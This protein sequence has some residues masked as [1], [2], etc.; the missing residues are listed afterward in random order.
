MKKS[1]PKDKQLLRLNE[2]VDIQKVKFGITDKRTGKSNPT[3]S[4]FFDY[5]TRKLGFRFRVPVYDPE[6]GKYIGKPVNRFFSYINDKNWKKYFKSK[7][8]MRGFS[9]LPMKKSYIA[10]PLLPWGASIA[11][12]AKDR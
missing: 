7:L 3:F 10:L 12:G 1:K 9:S 5:R 8:P 2:V 11:P 6:R 4:F